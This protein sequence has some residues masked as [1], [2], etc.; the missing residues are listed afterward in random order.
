MKNNNSEF[1]TYRVTWS[2]QDEEHVGL[3]AEFPGL[4]YL[5]KDISKALKGVIKLVSKVVKDMKKNKEPIPEPISKRQYSGK[6][7]VRISPDKHRE[8]SL[9]AS[10]QGVSLN[11]YISSRLSAV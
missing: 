11:H 1:Y 2:S 8:L 9:K 10:E 6:F 5:D 7:V 4:S 3:C